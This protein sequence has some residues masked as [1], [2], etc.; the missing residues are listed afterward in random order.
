[1]VGRPLR[2]KEGRLDG[3]LACWEAGGEMRCHVVL[4]AGRIWARRAGICRRRRDG[5]LLAVLATERWRW[6]INLGRPELVGGRLVVTILASGWDGAGCR[7]RGR[8]R[9]RLQRG[10]RLDPGQAGLE[11]AIALRALL[12][13]S[14]AGRFASAFPASSGWRTLPPLRMDLVGS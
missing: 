4:A 2:R 12:G 8:Q 3:G 1:V 7:N 6:W 9:R 11:P 5:V 13:P 14:F 10:C